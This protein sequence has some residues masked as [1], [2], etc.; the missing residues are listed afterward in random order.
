MDAKLSQ[1]KLLNL[2]F[3]LKISNFKQSSNFKLY[4]TLV[5]ITSRPLLPSFPFSL[6]ATATGYRSVRTV[7]YTTG[8]HEDTRRQ[9]CKQQA[10]ASEQATVVSTCLLYSQ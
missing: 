9:A 2:E 4:D 6:L 10:K 8:A 7:S 1:Q 5:V 3:E